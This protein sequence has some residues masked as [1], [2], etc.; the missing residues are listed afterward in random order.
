MYVG[1]DLSA[2]KLQ[3]NELQNRMESLEKRMDQLGYSRKL[4]K[5]NLSLSIYYLSP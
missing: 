2:I 4:A 5:D 1:A 3:F